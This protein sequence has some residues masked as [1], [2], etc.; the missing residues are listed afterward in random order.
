MSSILAGA[1]RYGSFPLFFLGYNG[2][3]LWLIVRGAPE[4]WRYALLLLAVLNLLW[5][6]RRI[7][8]QP[9]WNRDHGDS[10]K[11][12]L[13]GLVNT[14]LSY[15]GVWAL[16]WLSGYAPLSG[17]W[18]AG[19]PWL[20]QFLFSLLVL[21]AGISLAHYASHRWAPLWRFHAVHHGLRRLYGFNGWMK[22]PVH[23]MIETA[24]C[25]L[26]LWLLGIPPPLA[27][28]LGFCVA[29]QLL[30]Q[31]ANADYRIGPLKAWFATAEV[32]RY[33]HALGERGD[34]NFGLFTTLWDRLLGSHYRPSVPPPRRSAELGVAGEP[35]FPQ[36]Y[37][38]Q[39]RY[40]FSAG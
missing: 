35:D 2:L 14:G 11:D 22:H 28:G 38:A 20:L 23:Q 13:H 3:A 7:P 25:I 31:H 40:P 33:H 30:L 6:E 39:L 17:Y 10:S 16:P 29:I 27:A 19:W 34:V 24:A 5:I 32:H 21:D 18:P 9:D 37:L 12:L 8:W 26:P 15:A 4:A 36:A 1:L